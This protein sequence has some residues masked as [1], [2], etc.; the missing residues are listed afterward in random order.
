MCE[1]RI[2]R[3]WEELP[4]LEMIFNKSVFF[5]EGGFTH[6]LTKKYI[7]HHLHGYIEGMAMVTVRKKLREEFGLKGNQDFHVGEVKK[8]DSCMAYI[9]KTHDCKYKG[10]DID[11][12]KYVWIPVSEG[13]V[14]KKIFE[15]AKPKQ[16][17]GYYVEHCVNYMLLNGKLLN[18][19]QVQL[20]VVTYMAQT[21]EEYKRQII[22]KIVHDYYDQLQR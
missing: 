12:S 5:A 1:V 11:F 15:D 9:S 2:T 17:F 19:R 6:P 21:D 13:S 3:Q 8:Y 4:Q 7:K 22:D 10:L 16:K 20:Y 18:P 14:I